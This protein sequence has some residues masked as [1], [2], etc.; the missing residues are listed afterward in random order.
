VP[1]SAAAL[2]T[3]AQWRLG[4]VP[5]E[6]IR[7]VDAAL[8]YGERSGG[9]RT[10]LDAKTAWAAGRNDVEHHVFVPGPRDYEEGRRHELR[11][12]TV[13]RWN[14]YRLPASTRGLEGLLR[15]LEPDIVLAHDPFWSLPAAAHA[16]E[17]TNTVVVAVAHS[18]SSLDAAGLPGPSALYRPFL[19]AQRRHANARADAVL[20]AYGPVPGARITLPLRLGLDPAFRPRPC[21]ERGDHVLYAGR[22][23]R[24]KG[25]FELLAAAQVSIERW[26]LRIVGNGPVEGA[27][28][29]I[30][31]SGPLAGRVTFEPF[32]DDPE[33][34]AD[35]YASASCVVAPGPF[36]TFGLVTL[37]A[38]ASGGCVV[39]CETTPAAALAGGALHTF[40]PGDVRALLAAIRRARRASPDLETA[41]ELAGGNG[42]DR[43]LDAELR[44]LREL[45]A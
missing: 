35:A 25:I 8:W 32:I 9:I 24:E 33:Q 14:G 37:E 38:A 45:L 34:L 28:R 17:G 10:Y 29:R 1:P 13:N 16:A 41:A 39:A 43:A 23:A 30:A 31:A 21:V 18:S 7:M 19:S 6:P 26:P 11:A 42:W 40:P 44:E 27:A 22:I 2:A 36:E 5:S 4:L 20:S 15:E 12:R 3:G